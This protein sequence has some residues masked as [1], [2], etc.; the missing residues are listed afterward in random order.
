MRIEPTSYRQ[1]VS[2]LVPETVAQHASIMRDRRSTISA[3]T[4][5]AHALA[6]SHEVCSEIRW[7]SL[8]LLR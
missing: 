2:G 8:Q 1:V 6:L 5:E 4:S 3:T 7:A